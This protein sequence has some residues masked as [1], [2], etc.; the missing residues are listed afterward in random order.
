MD[1]SDVE[2]RAGR[3][4]PFEPL[5]ALYEAVG[6]LAYTSDQGRQDLQKAVHNATYVVSAW[7]GDQLIGLA[8]TLSD[9][10]SV[11]YLQDLLVHPDF[12]RQGIGKQ[13][14]EKCLERFRHVRMH[15]LVTDDEA[16]QHQFYASMGYK[17][18]ANLH[19][20]KLNAF[21]RLKGVDLE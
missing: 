21:V 5:L 4:V 10:V 14:M 11:F 20:T 2:I 16:R 13:L 8:R 9:D 1:S 19:K 3:D 7:R 18:T 12:Q 17:N 6:W 15:V